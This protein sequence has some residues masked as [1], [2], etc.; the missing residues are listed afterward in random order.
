MDYLKM[1]HSSTTWNYINKS[2]LH[3]GRN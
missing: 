1:M 3:A 2:K